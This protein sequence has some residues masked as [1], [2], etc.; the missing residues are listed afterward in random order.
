ME[1]FLNE[2]LKE[3]IEKTLAKS[4]ANSSESQKNSLKYFQRKSLK[5]IWEESN[6]GIKLLKESIK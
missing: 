4:R 2:P 6:E 1:Q 5:E 3:A